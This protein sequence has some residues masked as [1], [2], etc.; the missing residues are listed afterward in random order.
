MSDHE[1]RTYFLKRARQERDRA[2]ASEDNATALAHRRMAD[3]YEA[4][5]RELEQ[6]EASQQASPGTPPQ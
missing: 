6:L 4:R 2:D 5:T 3:A 1:E